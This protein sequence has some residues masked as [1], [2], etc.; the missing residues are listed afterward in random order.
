MANHWLLKTEPSTY[1]F[2]QL[3]KDKKTN[4][5]GVRN[6][7]ARKNLLAMKKGD[8][9]LIYHSNEGKSVVGIAEIASLPY[10]DPDPKRKGDWVQVD[11]KYQK[12][13]KT[14]VTLKEIKARKSFEDFLL[15]RVSRL[16]V[17]P[18]SLA[19]FKA[20]LKMGGLTP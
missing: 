16:S 13:L 8:L 14:P 20:I 18:V 2:E 9:A 17:M 5:N 11:V 7:R 6:F 4:W 19:H 10:P 12:P 15:V 1:S 3:K